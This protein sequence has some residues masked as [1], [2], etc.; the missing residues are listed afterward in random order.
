MF[1]LQL[2]TLVVVTH[3]EI[4]V[5]P[6]CPSILYFLLASYTQAIMLLCQNFHQSF[7]IIFF[8]LI[9]SFLPSRTNLSLTYS[10]RKWHMMQYVNT[11]K[12]RKQRLSFASISFMLVLV[13][14]TMMMAVGINAEYT[15]ETHMSV[16]C[17]LKSTNKGCVVSFDSSTN[18]FLRR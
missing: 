8:C 5:H 1:L 12:K 6:P 2:L 11:K 3:R 7:L 18:P 13:M 15:E 9:P 17:G 14:T 16:R 4:M 10:T